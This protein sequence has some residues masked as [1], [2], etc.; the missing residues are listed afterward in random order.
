MAHL[1][2]PVWALVGSPADTAGKLL[3]GQAPH[4]GGVSS[5]RFPSRRDREERSNRNPEPRKK[6][7]RVRTGEFPSKEML[8]KHHTYNIKSKG[9]GVPENKQQK[10]VRMQYREHF[11]ERGQGS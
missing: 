1:S 2:H 7:G 9:K 10:G 11:R 6:E 8:L 4:G 3:L 5:K